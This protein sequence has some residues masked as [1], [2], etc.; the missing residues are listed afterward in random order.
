MSSTEADNID[1]LYKNYD[2]LSDAK[3]TISEVS[4]LMCQTVCG[5]WCS[6]RINSFTECLHMY[7]FY[8]FKYLFTLHIQQHEKECREIIEAVKVDAKAALAGIVSTQLILRKHSMSLLSTN[9]NC[10]TKKKL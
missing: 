4:I 10:L 8:F 5:P 9:I 1:N 2:I 6:L 3:E 7:I